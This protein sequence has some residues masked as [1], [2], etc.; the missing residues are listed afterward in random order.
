MKVQYVF[1]FVGVLFIFSSV[2]Y[3]AREFIQDLPNSIKLLL[4]IVSVFVS[5][6]IAEI[7]RGNEI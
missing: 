2:I 3:F 7:L 4:L 6:F 5:F 1:Y